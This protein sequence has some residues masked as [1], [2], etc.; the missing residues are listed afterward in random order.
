[1]YLHNL[2]GITQTIS[3]LKPCDDDLRTNVLSALLRKGCRG[4]GVWGVAN[5]QLGETQ[6]GLETRKSHSERLPSADAA[7]DVAAVDVAAVDVAA[8]CQQMI[9]T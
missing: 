7:A 4:Y 2:L 3:H 1:M 9:I 6:F 8:G 5:E